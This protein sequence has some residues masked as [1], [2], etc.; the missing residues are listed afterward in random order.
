M[1]QQLYFSRNSQMFLEIGANV[2]K[3]PVLDGFSFSQA[4][5]TSEITL[6]EMEAGDGTSRRGRRAFNDSLAPVDFSFSTYI[7]PFTAAVGTA[8]GTA[9]A[10]GKV[11]AVEEALWALFS[12]RATYASYGF[13]N[14]STHAT[15]VADWVFTDSNK[16]TLGPDTAAGA[17]LYFELGDAS[18]LC[19][20]LSKIAINEASIDFDIDGVAQINWSGFADTVTDVTTT[21]VVNGT[22][23]NDV[24]EVDGTPFNT[25]SPSTELDRRVHG[26][27][28]KADAYIDGVTDNNTASFDTAQVVADDTVLTL[29]GPRA[30]VYEGIDQTNNFIRNRLTKCLVNTESDPQDELESTYV[31]TLTGGNITLNNNISY[32]TPEELG[33]VNIPIGHVTGPRN[34]GGSFTCYLT[35]DDTNV[36]SSRDFFGD[37]TS[38]AQRSEVTNDFKL[39]FAIGGGDVSGNAISDSDLADTALMLEFP[40]CHVDIPTHSVEDIITLETTFM[41]LPD[42]IESADEVS[43][44]YKGPAA[45]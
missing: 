1:A 2:W 32:L 39:T 35:E 19:Y 17:S 7:R 42:S 25:D 36:N 44:V 6:A 27:G 9:D 23:G 21:V 26:T 22:I 38:T 16:S 18:R 11:H 33:T 34:F 4:T 30:T 12:G 29:L 37:L 40:R 3:I 8:A 10:L 28:V 13:T 20:K 45:P 14:Q 5:N 31:L 15:D 41:A 43:M 24:L